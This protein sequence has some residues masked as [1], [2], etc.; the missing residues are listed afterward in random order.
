MILVAAPPEQDAVGVEVHT[1]VSNE[2]GIHAYVNETLPGVDCPPPDK[3]SKPVYDLARVP[4]ID[5]KDVQFHIETSPA[6]SC[7]SAPEAKITCRAD[8]AH[9]TDTTPFVDKLNVDPGTKVA[10]IVG[11]FSSPRPVIDLTWTFAGLPLGA[12]TKMV[13]GSRGTAVSFTPDV[14]GSYTLQVEV[15][16]DLQR[17]GTSN[18]EVTVTPKSPLVLQLIWTKF[19]PDDDPSTFPRIQLWSLNLNPDGST[20][21]VGGP[22]YRAPPPLKPSKPGAAPPEPPLPGTK[23]APPLVFGKS[24]GCSLESHQPF[25]KAQQMGFTTVMT[26]DPSATS[27]FGV[28]VHFTDDRVEGQ[29]VPCVRA[30]RDGKLVTDLCETS[31]HKA[32]TW[33]PVGVFDAASGKTV[34]ALANERAAAAEKAAAEKAAA[35]AKAAKAAAEAKAAADAA[36]ARVAAAASARAAASATPPRP[37]SSAPPAAA[38]A[39]SAASPKR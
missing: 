33:W 1:V 35:D 5:G 7:G 39:T 18:T 14:F 30:Y 16:D 8:V 21:V 12:A 23:G 10:C 38:P 4:L 26:M 17:R 6:D 13:V 36:V 3:D 32:D 15:L 28:A 20:V 25:C 22:P 19:D 27:L 2:G 9:T 24:N 37:A 31:P 34:Q 11:K 29:A